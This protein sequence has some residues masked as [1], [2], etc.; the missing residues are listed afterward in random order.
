[1]RRS[2][3]KKSE[4]KGE[5][6]DAGFLFPRVLLS[7][8]RVFLSRL[9]ASPWGSTTHAQGLTSVR[10]EKREKGNGGTAVYVCSG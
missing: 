7:L 3:T 4:K 5:K 2:D 1:M 9:D 10:R 6:G 8:T